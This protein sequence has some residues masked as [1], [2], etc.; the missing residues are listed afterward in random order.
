MSERVVLDMAGLG[1]QERYKLLIGSVVPRP[2]ALV[3]TLDA[4]GRPNL[5]PFSFFCGISAEPM[6]VAFCPANRD[7]GGPKDTLRNCAPREEGGTGELV[8]NVVSRAMAER[9]AACAEPLEHGVSEFAL[10]GLTAEASVMVG[11]ACVGESPVSLECRTER[12][13]RFAPG[14]GGGGNMVI[15]R[16]LCAHV[17]TS[18]MDDR[19][20]L[21]PG[22]LDAIGRMG[23]LAYCT[24]RERFALPMGRDALGLIGSG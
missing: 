15:A 2:I 4:G 6:L 11:P 21:D 17:R 13:L 20:R 24:T 3:S 23:G 8:I 22:E 19:L 18:A 12:V 14:V 16:V 5:A 7:D 10:S 9:M 1:Q